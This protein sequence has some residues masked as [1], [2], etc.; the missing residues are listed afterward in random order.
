MGGEGREGG[1]VRKGWEGR[2]ERRGGEER[3]GEGM[4]EEGGRVGGESVGMYMRNEGREGIVSLTH[5]TVH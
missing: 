5:S 2:G 3:G 4:G 1:R